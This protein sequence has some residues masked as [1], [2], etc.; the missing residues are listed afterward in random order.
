MADV[1]VSRILHLVISAL[2]AGSVVY[3][4]WV[5][6]P[7]ARDGA[8]SQTEPLYTIT[9]RLRTLSRAS[10]VILLLTGGHLAGAVYTAD[11]LVETTN[12]QL[13][14]AMTALWLVLIGLVEVATARFHRGL[15]EEKLRSPAHEMI[16]LFRAAALVAL[17]VLLVA[18]A[19]SANA[20][21]VL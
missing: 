12:G 21:Q 17:V 11:S 16:T 13:V 7:L 5:V 8:F 10:A 2:W 4:A 1:V 19:I 6:L 20:V 9:G 3:V 15:D 18:G 14:L